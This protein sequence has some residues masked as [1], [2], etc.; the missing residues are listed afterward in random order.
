[1]MDALPRTRAVV[2]Q[3]LAAGLHRGAQVCV[4]RGGR[5]VAEL[6]RGESRPGVPMTTDT[7]V[8]WLSSGKPVAAVAA[9]QQV[10]R[11]RLALD[12]PISQW[13]PEFAEASAAKR[14]VTLRH[15]LTHTSG[16][17]EVDLGWPGADWE[18]MVAR[19]CAAPLRPDWE[20]GQRAAYDASAS[21]F[22]VAELVQRASGGVFSEYVRREIFLPLGMHDCWLGMPPAQ[23][24]AYGPRLAVLPDT[25]GPDRPPQRY[26]SRQGATDCL[27]GANGRGPMRELAR[28]Y[29]MLLA[30]GCLEGVQVLRPE[31]AAA[32]TARQRA[33][34]RDETFR[35]R[36]DWGLGIMVNTPS[37]GPLPMPYGYGR[38]ASPESFGHGGA[39]SSVVFADPARELVVAALANGMPGEA[40]HQRRMRLWCEA[41]YADLG[42]AAGD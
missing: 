37:A 15:L 22:L 26:C 36:V 10:E 5:I 14:R 42:L 12:E 24:E 6:A 38:F 28:L 31:T 32:M 9:M 39:Q 29:E 2:D 30:G 23:W 35:C 41:I 4:R 13:L 25:S 40:E 19:V 1:M 27:P 33:G 34:M 17:A 20:P 16:L 8:L 7:V 11:G 21:W 3:G 18:Q